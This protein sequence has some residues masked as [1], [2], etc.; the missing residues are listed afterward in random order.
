MKHYYINLNM[1][2]KLLIILFFSF[3]ACAY[4]K[5]SA[6]EGYV[7]INIIIKQGVPESIKIT[8]INFLGESYTKSDLKE[9]DNFEL[10]K[11]PAGDYYWSRLNIFNGRYFNLKENKFSLK[12]VAGKI[13]YGGHLLV[14]INQKFG[15]A[16]LNY[17]NR[18]STVIDQLDTC[19]S[20]LLNAIPL[21]YTG[22]FVDPFIEFYQNISSKKGSY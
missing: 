18:S 17:M 16:N 1:N 11:L 22:T 19:C 5:L 8:S 12:V 7:A 6:N 20:E 2:F 9:G 13:N 4:E 10:I 14:D 21:I 3:N 15:T